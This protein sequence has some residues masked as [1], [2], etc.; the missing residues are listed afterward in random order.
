ML[1]DDNM[2]NR[3]YELVEYEKANAKYQKELKGLD[4]PMMP[5]EAGQ[6]IYNNTDN[7]KCL[8]FAIVNISRSLKG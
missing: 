5:G 7:F 3:L 1:E 4:R 8:Y 2:L 6:D